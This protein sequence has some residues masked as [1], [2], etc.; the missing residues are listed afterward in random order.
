MLLGVPGYVNILK[1]FVSFLQGFYLVSYGSSNWKLETQ[2]SIVN[3]IYMFYN[4]N[5][6]GDGDD[7]DVI[8]FPLWLLL[9]DQS[10]LVMTIVGFIANMATSITLLKNGQVCGSDILSRI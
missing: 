1:T 2:T 3:S 10:Q 7:D 8:S 4:N 9:M 5:T 6:D